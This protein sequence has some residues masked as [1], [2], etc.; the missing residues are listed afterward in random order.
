MKA[1][2]VLSLVALALG[3]NHEVGSGVV[4]P[5]IA[6]AGLDVGVTSEQTAQ[7]LCDATVTATDGSYV[8]RL[9]ATSCRY[10]G[11]FE[12]P[13]TYVLRAEGTGFL[14]KEVSD[15]RVIMGTGQCPHVQ[16]VRLDIQLKTE[17]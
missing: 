3:C 5:A 11:A 9:V 6:M 12:R 8:E 14:A 13:G 17:P 7:A 15:V 4:C 16:A 2:W 10:A 1:F